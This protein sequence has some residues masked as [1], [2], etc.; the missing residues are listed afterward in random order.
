[1]YNSINGSICKVEDFFKSFWC[2]YTDISNKTYPVDYPLWFLRDLMI[3]VLCT[4]LVNKLIKNFRYN[5]IIL[6]GVVWFLANI[7]SWG[8]LAQFA[9]AFFFFSFGAYM[10][11]NKKDIIQEFGKYSTLSIFLFIFLGCCYMVLFRIMPDVAHAIMFARVLVGLVFAYNISALLLR[12][13]YCKVNKFLA[14]SSFFIYLSHV[15]FLGRF[16]RLIFNIIDT[17]SA[18][19]IIVGQVMAVVVTVFM[20][21]FLYCCGKRFV[22]VLFKVMIGGR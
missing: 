13:G 20:L 1:M 12:R 10:S 16:H 8:R 2:I 9:S 3:V 15:F 22:P 17:N 11:I 5:Y 6:V 4:P 18:F 14:Q 21:L 7:L 19:G